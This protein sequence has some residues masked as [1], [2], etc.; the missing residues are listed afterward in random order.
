MRSHHSAGQRHQMQRG[1]LFMMDGA[2][3]LSQ[4][5]VVFRSSS[6]GGIL[7]PPLDCV[8]P[9]STISQQN[10]NGCHPADELVYSDIHHFLTYF[11]LLALQEKGKK[12]MFFDAPCKTGQLQVDET[13]VQVMAPFKRLVWSVPREAVTGISQQQGRLM[14]DLTIHTAQ[15]SY[16]AQMLTRQN[17]ARFFALFPN[18][19]VNMPPQAASISTPA[20]QPPWAQYPSPQQGPSMQYPPAHSYGQP[21]SPPPPPPPMPPPRPGRKPWY[22]SPIGCGILIGVLTLCLCTVAIG[23]ALPPTTPGTATTPTAQSTFSSQATLAPPDTPTVLAPLAP[24]PTPRPSAPTPTPTPSPT[25]QPAAVPTRPPTPTA[26]PV[27][28]TPTPTHCI[29]VNNNPWC[30]DFS[31]GK[32]IYSPPSAFCTYFT[33]VS[34]FWTATSGY[35]AE[36][37]DGHY[38]HSGGVSGACSHNGGVLRALYSH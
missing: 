4:Q 20:Q 24:T 29:G 15:G 7:C 5:P 13:T 11:C 23:K 28:P 34:T 22:R 12:A 16:P 21:P 35:V 9:I 27:K 3:R 8:P 31:P 14:V 26:A 10:R 17:A 1:L 2:S 6:A 19:K 37:V 18:R 32:Y 36:C 30:Y 25:R 33:C 38:T